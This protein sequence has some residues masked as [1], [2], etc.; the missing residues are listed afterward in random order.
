MS[1][2]KWRQ[3][4]LGLNVLMKYLSYTVNAMDNEDDLTMY[5][6]K[7][8]TSRGIGW[9]VP[10][11]SSSN[12]ERITK[13]FIAKLIGSYN[14]FRVWLCMEY[15]WC[16]V[17]SYYS[18]LFPPWIETFRVSKSSFT[19]HLLSPKVRAF[20]EALDIGCPVMMLALMALHDDVIKW[21]QFPR[22]WPFVRGIHRSPVN[23]PHKGQWRGALM[24]SLIC[25]W[26]NRWINNR[27]AGDLRRYRTHYDTT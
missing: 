12:T 25:A 11:Y 13:N 27:E 26:I 4:C 20:T 5:G 3:F 24:F 2:A 7:D 8:I 14:C 10:G 23:S 22:Y 21:K 17:S 18:H 6:A 16:V 9:H 1:S 15:Q 19:R